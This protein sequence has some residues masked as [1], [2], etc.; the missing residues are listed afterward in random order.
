MHVARPTGHQFAVLL[1]RTCFSCNF[2]HVCSNLAMYRQK[3]S[4]SAHGGLCCF[5]G[6]RWH[7]PG[8]QHAHQRNCC[9][10]ISRLDVIWHMNTYDVSFFWFLSSI[11]LC[12]SRPVHSPEWY[13]LDRLCILRMSFVL[14]VTVLMM[15]LN[16]FE[17]TEWFMIFF[18]IHKVTMGFAVIGV[19]NGGLAARGTDSQCGFLCSC[20]EKGVG[21]ARWCKLEWVLP[22]TATKI[23]NRNKHQWLSRPRIWCHALQSTVFFKNVLDEYV[24]LQCLTEC[25]W[26]HFES[27]SLDLLEVNASSEPETKHFRDVLGQTVAPVMS[28]VTP[29]SN[30]SVMA[31][32]QVFWCK[33]HSKWRPTT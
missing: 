33:R 26:L 17:V 31:W 19:I 3:E 5:S 10:L 6:L 18:L 2:G 20:R 8:G 29:E 13:V 12:S 30:W 16:A 9:L 24:W 27:P 14:G 32:R 25:F 1:L 21:D 11:Q 7:E 4:A 28:T 22:H 15:H 23:Q